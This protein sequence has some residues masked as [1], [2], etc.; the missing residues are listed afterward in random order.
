MKEKNSN[1]SAQDK[2]PVSVVFIGPPGSGK[3]TTAALLEKNHNIKSVSPGNIFKEIR[4]QNN[5]LSKL[6]IETTKNGGLCPDWLTN[7]IVKNEAQ[8]LIKEGYTSISLDGY[9]RTLEQ[10]DFLLA[11]YDVKLFVH[12]SAHW[13]IL[14]QK[15]NNRRNCKHCKKVFSIDYFNL[16]CEKNGESNCA[17][18]SELNWE[19][20]WDDNSD[21]F[22]RRYQVYLKE[23]YPI[24]KKIKKLNTYL[25]LNLFN[26]ESI[27]YITEKII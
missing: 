11:N 14:E 5:D 2:I 21:I 17:A 4:N 24:I 23:T 10:L 1:M 12:A 9:P 6:V 25:N 7:E 8:K 3:G 20:R 18:T 13:K 26:N 16:M 22:K 15:I 27:N 19:T